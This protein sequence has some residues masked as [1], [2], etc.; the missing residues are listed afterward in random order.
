MSGVSRD[1]DES[2]QAFFRDKDESCL[3][4]SRDKDELGLGFPGIGTSR[5]G[6]FGDRC[7][8][9]VSSRCRG[10]CNVDGLVL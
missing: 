10:W 9:L 8:V 4:F 5:A 7:F 2:V 3:V 1:K 6:D